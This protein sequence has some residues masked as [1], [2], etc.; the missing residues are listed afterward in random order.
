ML[1]PGVVTFTAGSGKEAFIWP[2]GPS[3]DARAAGLDPTK[4][5]FMKKKYRKV[6]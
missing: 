5:L 3:E 2:E 6:N 4:L 1:I